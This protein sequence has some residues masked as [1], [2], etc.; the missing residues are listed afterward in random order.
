MVELE[1]V[2]LLGVG[3]LYFHLEPILRDIER[4]TSACRRCIS[5]NILN[6]NIITESG[7]FSVCWGSKTAR[8]KEIGW[9]QCYVQY[10]STRVLAPQTGSH[11]RQEYCGQTQ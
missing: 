2:S 10:R 1:A 6:K 3:A 5:R 7:S 11:V 8:E 9:N 4:L